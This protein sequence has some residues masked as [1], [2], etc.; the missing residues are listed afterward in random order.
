[1]W[2]HNVEGLDGLNM[3]VNFWWR[4]TPHFMGTPVNVLKHA[5]LAI[6]GLRPEQR[7]AWRNILEYYV[8]YAGDEATA[9]IPEASRGILGELDENSA[10]QL[11]AELLNLLNR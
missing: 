1:M 2:W 4:S 9:H 8:F 10:R 11:R 6:R 3:L 7:E 5:L